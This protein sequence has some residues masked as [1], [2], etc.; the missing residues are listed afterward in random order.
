MP[1]K[2]KPVKSASST[3][4]ARGRKQPARQK[5]ISLFPLGFDAAVEGLLAVKPKQ[6]QLKKKGRS[7]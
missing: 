2:K 3:R 1:P 7:K 4:K 5:P 6:P